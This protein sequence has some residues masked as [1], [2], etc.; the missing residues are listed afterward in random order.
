MTAQKAIETQEK[1]EDKNSSLKRKAITKADL[2]ARLEEMSEKVLDPT[3]GLYG[4]GSMSWRVNRHTSIM[5]GA[6]CA[7]LLQLAHPWVAQAIDQHSQT[8]TDPLGRL[9]RTF[10]NVHTMVFGSLDQVLDSAIKVHNIH[11]K[12]TGQVSESAGQSKKGSAYFANQIGAMLWVHAT[13][14]ITGL[15][16]YELFHQPFTA[17]EKEQYYRESKL[18]AFL[19]GIPE[20]A[21]PETWVDFLQYY[22]G[23][24]N[25]DE[26][27]VGEVGQQLVEYIFSMKAYLKPFLDRHKVH[28]A[29]LLPERLRR[30]FG[31][32]TVTPA[33]QKQF[34]FDVKLA[35]SLFNVAPSS[36]KYMPPC[37]EACRR[38]EGEKAGLVTQ[39]T[40]RLLYGQ[41]LLVS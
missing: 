8:Q 24:V 20:S 6:G 13:L 14:W 9:R 27:A 22:E 33:L 30:D 3:V 5:M 17:A 38:L 19:F 40:N 4:P 36:V 39:F 26:L 10:L 23:V 7:N 35:R 16:V 41:P 37:L 29:V 32:P 11:A 18:F 25:S 28:T 34:D 15:R 1:Q 2:Q 21:M 31:F 12:I